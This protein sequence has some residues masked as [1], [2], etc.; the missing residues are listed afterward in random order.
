MFSHKMTK[1]KIFLLGTKQGKTPPHL[2]ETR[3]AAFRTPV[4]GDW[5]KYSLGGP[6]FIL[7]I[8]LNCFPQIIH[9]VPVLC[10][11]FRLRKSLSTLL[12]YPKTVLF[13]VFS[14]FGFTKNMDG[15]LA[16]S[17]GVTWVTCLLSILGYLASFLVIWDTVQDYP[18]S[19][20]DHRLLIELILIL[21][22]LSCLLTALVL[23][24]PC[25]QKKLGEISTNTKEACAEVTSLVQIKRTPRLRSI[26][27]QAVI[28]ES[29]SRL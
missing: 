19:R 12:N 17:R 20:D 23:H 16:L 26:S 25:L 13:P 28:T 29:R 8:I 15:K 24:L 18:N 5:E 14:P 21:F 22:F 2:N 3:L 11:K 27:V 10:V 7:W 6:D 9:A 4:C 1:Q